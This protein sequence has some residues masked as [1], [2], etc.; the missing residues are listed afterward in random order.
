MKLF[1]KAIRSINK[2]KR[3]PLTL[4]DQDLL[5]EASTISNKINVWLGNE[6]HENI[7]F[8]ENCNTSTYLKKTSNKNASYPFDWIF[9]SPEII[10]HAIKDDFKS[11]LDKDQI[12]QVNKK[13]AGHRFYHSRMFN[14]R[15]PLTSDED[16][17]YYV[18]AVNRLRLVL[19][20]QE[21]SVF[22]ITV[23]NE[24][25]KRLDWSNG[26]DM[27]IEKPI[28]QSLESFNPLVSYVKK[29]NPNSKFLFLSQITENKPSINLSYMDDTMLWVDFTSQG[30]CSGTKYRDR[31][32]DTIAKIIFQ[33]L[34]NRPIK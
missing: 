12:F 32:D 19:E 30:S 1:K 28:H 15:S 33:G 34:N 26:F 23:I 2:L 4:I 10:L 8:G 11:F 18:R 27:E 6:I 21:H 25:E 29:T 14:H 22:V 20:N 13:K 3:K 5:I 31:I 9:S 7:S 24:P 16:Y 17:N